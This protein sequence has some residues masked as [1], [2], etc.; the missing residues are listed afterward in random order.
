MNAWIN[1][2]R[3]RAPSVWRIVL[4]LGPKPGGK[5]R[6]QQW[7]TFRG[8]R[9]EA[10]L[11]VAGLKTD[12]ARGD[13]IRPAKLTFG[14]WADEWLEKVIR[15][16]R[17]ERTFIAYASIV[18]KHLN[19]RIGSRQL[20]KLQPSDVRQYHAE[21]ASR[22]APET[23]RLHHAVISGALKIAVEDGLVRRNVATGRRPAAPQVSQDERRLKGWTAEEARRVLKAARTTSPQVAALLAVALDSGGRRGELL[24]LRWTDI[25][26]TTGMLRISRQLIEGGASP[27]FG[28]TKTRQVRSL[29]LGAQT[30]SLLEDHKR[31]QAELKLATVTIN[32]ADGR[33]C[34][35]CRLTP[36]AAEE[37]GRLRISTADAAVGLTSDD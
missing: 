37:I 20:Q 33:G 2:K 14:E 35:S 34:C 26:L 4:D 13:F 28:D 3:S 32:T 12:H 29:L 25:D 24:A 18:R 6:I 16:G 7:T 23:C 1:E 22:F 30:L 8:T 17:S 36:E 27:R 31:E 19:P 5:G 9:R 15:P 21:N 10:D 11:H